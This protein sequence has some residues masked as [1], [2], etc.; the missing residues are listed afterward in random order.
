VQGP[1]PATPGNLREIHDAELG[2]QRR[3]STHVRST[4]RCLRAGW[5]GAGHRIP[6]GCSLP[7]KGPTMPGC[8]VAVAGADGGVLRGDGCGS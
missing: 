2:C 1:D 7:G 6:G 4:R 3:A 5:R 8:R